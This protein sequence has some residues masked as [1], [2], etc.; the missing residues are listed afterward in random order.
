MTRHVAFFELSVW[1]NVS[2]LVSG[3]LEAAAK[4]RPSIREHYSFEKHSVPVRIAPFEKLVSVKAD[5]YAIACY[6][7][8]TGFVMKR[9][10]PELRARNPQAHILLGGP[11]VMHKAAQYLSPADERVAICNGEGEETFAN[12]LEQLL[13]PDGDLATVKGLSFYRGGELVETPDQE[14]IQDFEQYPS[15]YLEGCFEGQ[16]FMCG[17]IETNRGCPFKCTYCYW[18]ASTNS[19]VRKYP[20][21]RVFGEIE[22]LSRNKVY[23]LLIADANLGMLKRDQEIVEFVAACRK[24]YGFPRA[25]SFSASKNTAPA[26]N[27]GTLKTFADAG[28]LS[29]LPVSIQSINPT[30][31]KNVDRTNIS[32]DGYIELQR[33]MNER[34][35]DSN[36][37][38]IWPLPGETL[39]SFK[40]GI[41]TLFKLGASSFN[42]FPLLLINNVQMADEREEFGL[43]AVRDPDPNSDAELVVGTKT[44]DHEDYLRGL[45]FTA[46]VTTLL[47]CYALRHVARL[48]EERH[49]VPAD[50]L[51]DAFGEFC[52]GVGPN[53][54]VDYVN[55]ATS[56]IKFF[57]FGMLGSLFHRIAGVQIREFD[58]LLYAFMNSRRFWDDEQIRLA[59]ELDLLNRPYAYKN[60]HLLD[61][62]DKLEILSL[63]KVGQKDGISVTIPQ[64]YAEVAGRLLHPRE[65][66]KAHL[67]YDIRYKEDQ[68]QHVYVAGKPEENYNFY[69]TG[70]LVR[71]NSVIPRWVPANRPVAATYRR[72]PRQPASELGA[73]A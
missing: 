40:R 39:E 12:Y 48:L 27:A 36:V 69:C 14:R 71:I 20:E 6:V 16:R 61:K 5:V 31:L 41:A 33:L 22:W 19:R 72:R 2:P 73:G 9:F 54:Y 1:D 3:L 34:G 13:Q 49:D 55:D 30:V 25:V 37:E 47:S 18:G 42:V 60:Q 59:F 28:L 64:E 15:P 53:V 35:N 4:Q 70:L 57:S 52:D 46:H 50:R 7:W 51:I 24:K 65:P 8:N 21:G 56:S 11:Q 17:V 23:L 63:T 26:R 32:T 43:V 68:S 58:E 67:A 38:L 10:V 44:V 62:S 66:G 45:R 29:S